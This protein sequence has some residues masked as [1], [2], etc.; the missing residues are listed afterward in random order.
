MNDKIRVLVD[1]VGGDVGQGILKSLL[2]TKLN[3]NYMP[4][5]LAIRVAGYIK[6]K[7]VIY[8]HW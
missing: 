5:V 6:L 7:I 8:F 2:N 1:G 3:M 4:H